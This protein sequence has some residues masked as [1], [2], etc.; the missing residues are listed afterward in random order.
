MSPAMAAPITQYPFIWSKANSNPE[1]NHGSRC[2]HKFG[3]LKDM[4][5]YGF[6]GSCRPEGPQVLAELVQ[7]P[8]ISDFVLWSSQ[9][10]W[11]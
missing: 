4:A 8:Q 5:V 3:A 9:F 1:E 7:E 10:H 2:G 11:G 6:G